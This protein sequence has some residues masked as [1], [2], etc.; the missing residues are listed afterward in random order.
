MTLRSAGLYTLLALL[1]LSSSPAV[2]AQEE[3]SSKPAKLFSSTETF[4]VT[5]TAP[6]KDIEKKKKYQGTYPAKIEF[7]DSLGNT[8]TLEL[9]VERRGITRQKVCRYPPIKLR[10]DKE[11][12]KGTTFR[13]QKSIKMVTH[14]DKG[15]KY[16]QY[17][18]L[19]MLAYRFYNLITDFSFKIR[20]LSITY[21]DSESG[22]AQ[23]PL[24]AFLIEDDSD[25]AKRNGQDKLEIARTKP[26]KL[27]PVEASNLS[28][29]QFMIANLDFAALSGPDPQKCC[30]NAKLLGLDP[31]NG[32]IY[33]VPYDFDSS[34][35]VDAHYAG[36][37][38]N[39]PVKSVTQRLFRGF[40]RHNDTLPQ[41]KQRFLDNEQA[42][43][44]LVDDEARL[45]AS[46]QKKATKFL[47]QYYKIIQSDKNFNKKIIE[48]C[49]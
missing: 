47:A 16:E 46:S 30:H 6:W 38:A 49:R 43:F 7:T 2:L 17:Y 15:D 3:D 25:V 27:D 10:F 13:G 8:N 48:K 39:L 41:A 29:F 5:L 33:P 44:A 20:P 4:E 36:P 45:S 18:I 1:L 12:A 11:T 31:V 24:F 9:T 37:P 14:C 22:K 35:F 32:P 21:I 26:S 34:G 28:L 40:C 42:I 23:D 19:E